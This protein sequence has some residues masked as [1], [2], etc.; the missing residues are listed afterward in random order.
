MRDEV[1]DGTAINSKW[2]P[3]AL[4]GF[5]DSADGPM[6]SFDFGER[7]WCTA[8]SLPTE[9]N[10]LLK[11]FA[12]QDSSGVAKKN[13]CLALGLLEIP[14]R[15]AWTFMSLLSCSHALFSPPQH[16]LGPFP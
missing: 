15:P 13:R 4:D 7:S 1:V 3:M 16:W 5:F 10:R 14:V 8:A 2:I 6:L 9:R 12:R 11:S